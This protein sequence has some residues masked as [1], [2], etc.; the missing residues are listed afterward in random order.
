MSVYKWQGQPVEVEHGLCL[1]TVNEEKPLYWYN[2]EASMEIGGKLI[3]AIK[4]K[5]KDSH[6]FCI[7]NHFGIGV[8]KLLNGG[9]PNYQHFS[10][11]I[12]LFDGCIPESMAI[13]KFNLEGFEEY[14]TN[15]RAWQK[16]EYPE[17][18]EKSERLRKSFYKNI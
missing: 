14:E 16:K 13:K 12:K 4:V 8:H 11:D 17:D 3:E 18:F 10:L 15:R 7:A 6:S 2:Y 9:W 1:V 5:V